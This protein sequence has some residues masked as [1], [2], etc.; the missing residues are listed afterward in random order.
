[1]SNPF[2]VLKGSIKS[3]VVKKGLD[4]AQSKID[5]QPERD[6]VTRIVIEGLHLPG[7]PKSYAWVLSIATALTNMILEVLASSDTSLLLSNWR[8]Y[9][10]AVLVALVSKFFLW[11]RQNSANGTA[12]IEAAT[13]N[14]INA[15]F[16]DTPA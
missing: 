1:M 15:T 4:E 6:Q 7:L 13:I 2:T 9:A 5:T 10:K 11:V 14:K 12:V 8:L 16:P 3:Y